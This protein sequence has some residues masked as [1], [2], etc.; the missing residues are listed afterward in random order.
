MRL[1]KAVIHKDSELVRALLSA[2]ENPNHC[3]DAAKLTPLHFAAQHNALDIVPLLITAGA[4]IHDGQTPLD[5]AKILGHKEMIILLE[6]Y[7]SKMPYTGEE[8]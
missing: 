6:E 8:K 2:G 7:G 5:I 1:I 3:L 4:N